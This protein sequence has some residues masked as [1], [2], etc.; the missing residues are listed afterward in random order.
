MISENHNINAGIEGFVSLGI[1]MKRVADSLVATKQQGN[2]FKNPHE[3]ALHDA[4]IESGQLNPWFNRREIARALNAIAG[5]LTKKDL[6]SWLNNYP[7][8][9]KARENPKKIAVI[10]AGNIPLVGFHDFLCVLISG[11][12]FMG[13]LSSQDALLP[14][15]VA[16]MLTAYDCS[17]V[18]RIEFTSEVKKDTD[19]IIATGSNNTARYF[20]YHFGNK[21]HLIRKNRNSA[22]VLTGKETDEEME[23]LGEDVFAYYGLGCRSVSHLLLPAGFDI[24]RLEKAWAKYHYVIKNKKFHNNLLHERAILTASGEEHV[25]LGHGLLIEDRSLVSPVGVLNYTSYENIKEAGMFIKQLHNSL[26]CV[27]C[28]NNINT[29]PVPLV[30]PGA[31]QY[32]GLADYADGV[33]TMSFLEK[34]H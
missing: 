17:L 14:L 8:L 23:K 12:R 11:H 22:A 26:Q 30:R 15:A 6:V 33:D 5:M 13:K 2:V 9:A 21:P 34:L 4:A 16:K 7:E 3:K 18:E 32:P 28:A 27:V 1:S 31:S 24:S 10:M 19:A 29:S 25:D 20:E